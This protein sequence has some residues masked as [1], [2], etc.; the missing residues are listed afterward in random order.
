MTVLSSEESTTGGS[1]TT[2]RQPPATLWSA[3]AGQDLAAQQGGAGTAAGRTPGGTGASVVVRGA[4]RVVGAPVLVVAGPAVVDPVVAG[5]VVVDPVDVEV[6]VVRV[7]A[8]VAVDD[9]G[10]DDAA[11][12]PDDPAPDE[13]GAVEVGPTLDAVAVELPEIAVA[14]EIA[15]VREGEGTT[16][17]VPLAFDEHPPTT[18]ATTAANDNSHADERRTGISSI[19]R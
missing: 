6:D 8:A 5:P 14:D 19:L 16:V 2:R 12:G 11:V 17:G 3:T 4:A 15:E 7:E 13:A 18:R 1:T 10:S 9:T